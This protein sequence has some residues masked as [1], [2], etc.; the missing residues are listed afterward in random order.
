MKR[1][2]HHY[3][4]LATL[5][6]FA[7][8]T[9]TTSCNDKPKP[10]DYNAVEVKPQFDGGTAGI[11]RFLAENATTDFTE[12]RTLAKTSVEFTVSKSGEVLSPRAVGDSTSEYAAEAVRL[13]RSMPRWQPGKHSG[14]AVDVR[15]TLPVSFLGNRYISA[16]SLDVRSAKADR[17]FYE[18]TNRVLTQLHSGKPL[19]KTQLAKAATAM[20]D[21]LDVYPAH[22]N[23]RRFLARVYLTA[24]QYEQALAAIDRYGQTAG[25]YSYMASVYRGYAYDEQ[26]MTSQADAEYG[27]AVRQIDSMRDINGIDICNKAAITGYLEGTDA[28]RKVLEKALTDKALSADHGL[29]KDVLKTMKPV[30]RKKEAHEEA[31]VVARKEK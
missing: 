28:K 22:A 8:S 26:G 27:K 21:V 13:V 19:T 3:Y 9:L 2:N 17:M 1:T 24:R 20:K 14:Q 4:K 11:D 30:N 29:I 16:D 15:M 7:L 18:E 5:A 23:A 12:H 31:C 25:H 10:H 6:L